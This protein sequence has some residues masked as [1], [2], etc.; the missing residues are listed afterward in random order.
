MCEHGHEHVLQAM[1][2]NEELVRR[3]HELESQLEILR[4][5]TASAVAAVA[6]EASR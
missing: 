1:T 2:N 4:A 5:A 3:V 6:S